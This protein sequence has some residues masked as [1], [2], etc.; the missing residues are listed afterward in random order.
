MKLLRNSAIALAFLAVV[1]APSAH[2][3]AATLEEM[4][5]QIQTL[6]AQIQALQKQLAE[7]RGEVQLLREG[8][9]EGMTS[10]DVTK[11]Q[12][13]LATDPTLYP[14][15]KV[16]GYFGPLTKN[17]IMRFELRHG[18]Q[19]TGEVSS[20][21]RE[22]LEQYLKEGFGDNIPPGLLRAPGIVK[23]V[24]LRYIEGCDNR[25]HGKGPLCKTLKAKYKLGDDDTS[26]DDDGGDGSSDDGFDV[27]V[28]ISGS[29]TVVSFVVGSTTHEVTVTGTSTDAVLAAVADELD[30][31]VDELDDT[32]VTE[33]K[34]E[35][36]KEVAKNTSDDDDD[37]DDD[38]DDDDDN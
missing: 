25:G 21:T 18:L 35:L 1:F 27:D 23:K 30:V 10:D 13:L 14:E 20:S 22:L 11:V 33:I 19:V 24:E 15:G 26:D 7:V 16:T 12:K 32:L 6:M 38:S 34:D 31:D 17:A 37:A 28:E 29:T 4:L 36:A 5:A 3:Q 2:A 9:H 8:L